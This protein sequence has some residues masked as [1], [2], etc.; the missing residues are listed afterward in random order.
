MVIFVNLESETGFKPKDQEQGTEAHWGIGYHKRHIP[1]AILGLED[2]PVGPKATMPTPK[3]DKDDPTEDG[4]F[5]FL[6][7]DAANRPARR[8]TTESV[9]RERID[10]ARADAVVS[11]SEGRRAGSGTDSTF[12]EQHPRVRTPKPLPIIR[13]P[14]PVSESGPNRSPLENNATGRKAPQKAAIIGDFDDDLGFLNEGRTKL[15][16]VHDSVATRSPFGGAGDAIHARPR[17]HSRSRSAATTANAPFERDFDDDWNEGLH[18][19][20]YGYE[21]ENR[22]RPRRSLLWLLLGG[23]AALG[24]GSFALERSGLLGGM[25]DVEAPMAITTPADSGA[26]VR[27]SVAE[28]FRD[29]LQRIEALVA[30]GDFAAATQTLDSLD[31]R[32]L[33]YGNPEF[34][35]LRDQIERGD[36]GDAQAQV[37]DETEARFAEQAIAADRARL[38]AEEQLLENALLVAEGQRVEAARQ[39]AEAQRVEEARLAA[40]AQQAEQARLAAEAQ[41]AAEA[42]LAAEAQRAEDARQAEAARVFSTEQARVAA[43]TQTP[44]AQDEADRL[45]RE[46]REV[47]AAEQRARARRA[48]AQRAAQISGGT[49]P[50]PAARAIT[51]PPSATNTEA[52]DRLAAAAAQN[53]QQL[54]RD[55]PVRPAPITDAEFNLAYRRFIDV[56]YAL[57][58]QDINTIT[59]LAE[60]NGTRV[61]NLLQLFSNSDSLVVRIDNV[62]TRNGTG[63][64]VGRLTIDNVVRR[65]RSSN[66][67]ANLR[68]FTLTTRR[69]ATGWSKIRW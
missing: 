21:N 15:G 8:K 35:A 30:A 67:P 57:E 11:R 66:P 28:Q 26:P 63:T 64:I 24:V 25:F 55:V 33:G 22:A 34:T 32:V 5:D 31:P 27:S 37:R 56:K 62:S 16:E 50:T 61:Q 47:I 3:S 68:S 36:T 54:R 44:S 40:E 39:A 2:P 7:E 23:I 20:D 51:S 65:G 13:K 12:E 10:E 42:R 17:P 38:A 45:E 1:T 43:A 60:T 4:M 53:A 59:Q 6:D 52:S 48:A 41:R 58:R 49:V 19:Y 29:D 46:R 18:D 9:P 14:V 69:D